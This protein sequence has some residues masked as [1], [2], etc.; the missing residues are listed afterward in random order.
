MHFVKLVVYA[1]AAIVAYAQTGNIST[2]VASLPV[3][4]RSCF[5]A[6]VAKVGCSATDSLATARPRIT[7]LSLPLRCHAWLKSAQPPR[8]NVC[9]L[10]PL[11]VR[12]CSLFFLLYR[13]WLPCW[14][15]VFAILL[16][17]RFRNHSVSQCLGWM[18]ILAD[19][20]VN[21]VGIAIIG[22]ICKIA[23]AAN[24]RSGS[25]MSTVSSCSLDGL[26]ERNLEFGAGFYHSWGSL[27]IILNT[28]SVFAAV[29]LG[30]KL[31]GPTQSCGG[32]GAG[33]ASGK[34][35]TFGSRK[36]YPREKC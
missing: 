4:V 13:P 15:C 20:N 16:K 24:N 21:A 29:Q 2:D 27:E 8:L 9:S 10:P 30:F 12:F 26:L 33:V 18:E 34:L 25:M 11:V 7:R 31:P 36:S 28:H 22:D 19:G 14:S 1:A 17:L 23:L 6:G 35:L 3:C 32:C 5:S